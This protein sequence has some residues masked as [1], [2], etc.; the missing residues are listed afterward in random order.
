LTSATKQV[1]PL[2]VAACMALAALAP[3]GGATYNW[4]PDGAGVWDLT[5]TH[6]LL[7]G[8]GGLVSWSS[9]TPFAEAEAV[10]GG[11]GDTVTIGSPIQLN[12]LT[13]DSSAYSFVLGASAGLTFVGDAPTI[14]INKAS[15]AIFSKPSSD[16]PS[17]ISGAVLVLDG[18]GTFQFGQSHIIDNT[19]AIELINNTKINLAEFSDTVGGFTLTG[20]TINGTTGALSASSY[21]LNDGVVNAV[22]GGSSLSGMTKETDGMVALNA[23]NTFKGSVHVNAGELYLG[24]NNALAKVSSVHVTGGTLTGAHGFNQSIQQVNVDGGQ[25]VLD[26]RLNSFGGV[27]VSGRGVFTGIGDAQGADVTINSGGIIE[28]GRIGA[29]GF[30]TTASLTLNQGGAYN[31]DVSNPMSGTAGIDWDLIKVMGDVNV[32]D[33]LFTLHVNGF[34]SGPLPTTSSTIS[35]EIANYTGSLNGFSN[36]K[37]FIDLAGSTWASLATM[38]QFS[39]TTENNALFLTMTPVPEPKDYAMILG[40]ITLG[41]VGYRRW[42]RTAQFA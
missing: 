41:L 10:F 26:G 33:A 35:W 39:I 19:T 17:T 6:F 13:I 9:A 7:N 34:G 18:G 3:A 15:T 2:V 29:A 5:S 28:P 4:S 1:A 31:W 22:L 37:F 8:Q 16:S 20:G 14:W 11:D 32:G 40:A 23:S 21:T 27:T 24:A 36:S 25:F 30:I 42:R 12:K 38:Y